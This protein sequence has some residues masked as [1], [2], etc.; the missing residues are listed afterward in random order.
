MK[1]VSTITIITV[2]VIVYALTPA[3]TLFAGES[4]VVN[5]VSAVANTGGNSAGTVEEGN[6][7]VEV[8]VEQEID[9]VVTPPIEIIEESNGE[10]I[11]RDLELVSPDGS[12]QTEIH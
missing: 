4:R 3:A 6:A 1:S 10:P 2:A 9:G 5:S 11:I 8:R 7:T 12:V